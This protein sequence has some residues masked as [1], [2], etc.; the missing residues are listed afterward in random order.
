MYEY[1]IFIA[2][3]YF[4]VMDTQHFL[5]PFISWWTF[6]LFPLM[7]YYESNAAVNIHGHS[8]HFS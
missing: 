4:I 5:H 2:K 7:G 3:E 6:E 8:F 1:F